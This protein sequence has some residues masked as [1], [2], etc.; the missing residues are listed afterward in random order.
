M[1]YL[2]VILFIFTILISLRGGRGRNVPLVLY[3]AIIGSFAIV[4]INLREHSPDINAYEVIF[5][6]GEDRIE[7]IFMLLVEFCKRISNNVL[8]LVIFVMIISCSI[9]SVLF[10]KM[11]TYP[12]L[13]ILIWVSNLFIMQETIAYRAALASALIFA[14]IYLKHSGKSLYAYVCIFIAFGFHFSSLI[15]LPL[16]FVS[17]EQTHKRFFLC[18]LL[19]SYVNY[20]TFKF[21]LFP[22]LNVLNHEGLRNLH[23]I[24]EDNEMANPL[25]MIQLANVCINLVLWSKIDLLKTRNQYAV[26]MLKMHTIGCSMFPLFFNYVTVAIRLADLLLL[27]SVIMYPLLT[28]CY[29]TRISRML[30]IAIASILGY[31]TITT[32]FF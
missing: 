9:K 20:L 15:G 1:E 13:S 25:N 4:S 14:A 27:S 30:P 31:F 17:K 3:Y 19:L 16:L 10:Y 12:L 5:H 24:Y 32:W 2:Y 28:D 11:S 22:F 23:S 29:R 26:V 18:F 21:D 6:S 7:P 8:V